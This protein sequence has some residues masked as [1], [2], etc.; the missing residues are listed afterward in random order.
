MRRKPTCARY[1]RIAPF[2]DAL[3]L[4]FE[5]LRYRPL[6][7]MLFSGLSGTIL[8]AGVGTGRN[9]PTLALNC[10]GSLTAGS[11]DP[12]VRTQAGHDFV[13]EG[14]NLPGDEAALLMNH[15][16]RQGRLLVVLQNALERS[17]SQVMC[18]LIGT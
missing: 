8:E 12:R 15:M 5:I 14:A 7:R 11:V 2:Y 9:M 18:N 16:H 13:D 10:R 1:R 4:P 6:R 17:Y 3:D